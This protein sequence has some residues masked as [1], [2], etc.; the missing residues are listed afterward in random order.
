MKNSSLGLL[1]LLPRIGYLSW[2]I[3][4]RK[5]ET[6]V[7]HRE[8]RGKAKGLLSACLFNRG[9]APGYQHRQADVF[10]QRAS[11]RHYNII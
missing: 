10:N 4:K 7:G 5:Q 1:C 8:C 2:F 6:E 3:F 11:S 9:I